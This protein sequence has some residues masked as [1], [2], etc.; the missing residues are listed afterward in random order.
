VS[1]ILSLT[2]NK[3]L[4]TQKINNKG[5]NN[6]YI[7]YVSDDPSSGDGF[8]IDLSGAT[9][10]VTINLSNPVKF[11]SIILRFQ[12]GLTPR[13]IVSWNGGVAVQW[14]GGSSGTLT[15][16]QGAVDIFELYHDGT[17]YIGRSYASNVS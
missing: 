2:G 9:G 10:N 6:F 3:V 16:S 17:Q 4:P 13:S 1:K 7:A 14:A 15:G 5:V 12:Q 11:S 8:N